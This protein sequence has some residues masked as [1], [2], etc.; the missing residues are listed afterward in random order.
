MWTIEDGIER[1][2]NRGLKITSQR[3]AIL[4]LLKGRKDH[5]S[6]E[7]IFREMKKTYSTISFATIYSTAQILQDA[8]LLQ[9]LTIDEHRVFFDPNPHPHAHFR[10][11][12]C[13][14][15]EDIPLDEGL[16]ERIRNSS[17]HDIDTVQVYCYGT[18]RSCG[19]QGPTTTR[20]RKKPR[21][22]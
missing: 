8:G 16:L 22:H 13:G 9:I 6:A 2:R 12:K 3:I 10:C 17:S 4:K 19:E 15:L 1:I 20:P 7:K 5:P 11:E 21:V 14:A 18:C